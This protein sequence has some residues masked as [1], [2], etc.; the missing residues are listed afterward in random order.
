MNNTPSVIIG[1]GIVFCD[2]NIRSFLQFYI[3]SFIHLLAC[4]LARS[5]AYLFVY[6]FVCFIIVYGIKCVDI[7]FSDDCKYSCEEI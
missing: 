2:V 4:L 6:L 5:P 7:S 1:L 3:H